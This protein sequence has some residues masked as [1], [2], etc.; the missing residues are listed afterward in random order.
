MIALSIRQP[1]AWL[2]IHAGKDIENRSWPTQFR[3]ILLVHASKGMTTAEYDEAKEFAYCIDESIAIPPMPLLERGGII[4]QV[5]LANCVA[6]SA[7][8][9][10]CGPYGFGL[11]EAKP[12]PFAPCRG[13]L[14]LFDVSDLHTRNL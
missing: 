9:W 2:I 6:E 7:S 8:P 13:Q 3:G 1:W 10:F 14:G 5:R 11:T 4:G 12:L